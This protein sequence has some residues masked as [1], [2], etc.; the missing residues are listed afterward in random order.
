MTA[1]LPPRAAERR[2]L[3]G[4]ARLL[5]AEWTK[6]RTVRGWVAGTVAAA[7]VTVLIGLLGTGGPNLDHPPDA[8]PIGPGGEA[9]N[10]S[11]YFVHRALRGDGSITVPV[12]SLTGI[13]SMGP[14][15]RDGV[16]PWAKAGIIVKDGLRPGS[17]YAAIMVT[18]G[19][20]MRMQHDYVH[21][22]AAP[23]AIA[24][25]RWLRLVRSGDTIT[26]YGSADGAHW[27][28]AGTARLPGLGST[29]QAGAFVA[30]PMSITRTAHG[31]SF[32]PAVATATF[33]QVALDGRWTPGAWKGEQI[34]RAGTSGSYTD[35]VHGG[36]TEAGR[37]LTVTGAGDIAPIVGGPALGTG[38]TI[39]NLL[40]GAF[41]GILVMAVIGALFVS[42][43]Y[44]RGL[45]R[46]TFAASPRRG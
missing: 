31:A 12:T 43:E 14:D 42:A 35:T 39:E 41:A 33:G 40:V 17:R 25:A 19:H 46:L 5:R 15:E 24:P 9:V 37:G 34:G 30:S 7:V 2:A 36:F 8:I 20:G 44:R 23:R 4:F 26:G 16:V 13:V 18:A 10:D 6:F 32:D 1:V 11:F 27:T 21:D 3:D 22:T 38:Y 29:V 28:P 45:V